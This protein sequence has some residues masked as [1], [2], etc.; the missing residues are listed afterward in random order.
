MEVWEVSRQADTTWH[1]MHTTERGVLEDEFAVRQL[2]TV[3][4]AMLYGV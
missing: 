2:W 4:E 3:Y 1:R